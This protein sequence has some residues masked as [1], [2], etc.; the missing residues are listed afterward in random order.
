MNKQLR[1]RQSHNFRDMIIICHLYAIYM[2][3]NR[4]RISVKIKNKIDEVI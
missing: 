2:P 1:E 4:R 3:F